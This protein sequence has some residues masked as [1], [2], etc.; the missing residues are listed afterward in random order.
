MPYAAS[1][2]DLLVILEE[3]NH[4]KAQAVSR[5]KRRIEFGLHSVGIKIHCIGD[6][7]PFMP[8]IQRVG[9]MEKLELNM[10]RHTQAS[11]C[12]VLPPVGSARTAIQLL[13]CIES[14]VNWPLFGN[15]AVQLQV[16]SPLRLD[17]R[18]SAMLAIGH[19]LLL[20]A[21]WKYE[22]DMFNMTASHDGHYCRGEHLVIYDA[23]GFERN[24]EWWERHPSLQA[25]GNRLLKNLLRLPRTNRIVHSK[26]PFKEGRTDIL[27]VREKRSIENINFLATLLA[28]AEYE[29]RVGYWKQL[30]RQLE[31]DMERLLTEHHLTGLLEAPWVQSGKD[32]KRQKKFLDALQ[33]LIAYANESAVKVRNGGIL[34][35]MRTLAHSY[36]GEIMAQS[37]EAI[38][39]VRT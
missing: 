26:L 7:A 25:H 8:L 32:K 16:C 29:G 30:G 1:L 17:P 38:G 11:L 34:Q 5:N 23:G 27:A 28:H 37:I 14:F 24:F 4:I 36:R 2:E 33:E 3:K 13:E 15:P 19:Y 6:G 20:G 22:P 31:A 10:Y 35:Q 12:M 18:R 21:L 9:G 39:G